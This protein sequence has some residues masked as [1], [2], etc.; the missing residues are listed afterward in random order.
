MAKRIHRTLCMTRNGP[1]THVIGKVSGALGSPAYVGRAAALEAWTSGPAIPQ[2]PPRRARLLS[3]RLG[4]VGLSAM[5]FNE[6][7]RDLVESKR[8]VTGSSTQCHMPQNT[9]CSVAHACALYDI[10]RVGVRV[11][12]A[13]KIRACRGSL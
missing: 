1:V 6:G 9:N 7:G 5:R 4:L 11:K 12:V 8:V 3:I 13:T 2:T 10:S